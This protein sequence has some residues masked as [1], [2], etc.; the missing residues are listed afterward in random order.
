MD[1]KTSRDYIVASGRQPVS[2]P[3]RLSS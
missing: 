2:K 3:L 1:N